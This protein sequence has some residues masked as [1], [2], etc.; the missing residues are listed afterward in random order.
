MIMTIA[1]NCWILRNKNIDGIGTFCI[2]NI[3][4][5][6]Q[7]HPQIHFAL[8]C[9]KNFNEDYFNFP[10]VTIYRIFPPYR[11][12]ALY[13]YFLEWTLPRFLK[14]IKP[15]VFVG[16]DGAIS[17]RSSCKQLAVIHDLNFEHYPQH[18]PLRNRLYYKKM[19]PRFAGKA[20]RI[21]TVSNYS[22][23]DIVQLY[24]IP[25]EK[26]DVIFSGIKNIDFSKNP[27]HLQSTRQ[28][29]TNG[30]PYFFF[31]GTMHQRKNILRLIE[32]FDLFKKQNPGKPHQLVLCGNIMWNNEALQA[33][34]KQTTFKKDI[35][36]TGRVT[37]S[38]LSLLLSAAEAVTF[39][40][41]F[42]GFGLPIV[43]A[44]QAGV[45]LICSNTSS[46]P[47]VAGDAALLVDPF[48]IGEI[49]HAM[50]RIADEEQLRNKLVLK[51]N[52]RKKM[53]S[54]DKTAALLWDSILKTAH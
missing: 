8:L 13:L 40:P 19:F 7:Q 49:A 17:L 35:I 22:K 33:K 21:A 28:K 5:L 16:V 26:I 48:N 34:L 14:K 30:N 36:L 42:E 32:A 20:N 12:P 1:F 44:F 53:F 37:D 10:N 4:R 2:E 54:W 23:T 47:E 3:S 50:E 39:V 27:D 43:E 11:H 24:N 38:E 6:A 46:L 9:D 31:V 51:G 41:L 45:P 25:Q 18:L 29:Y 52:E 15:D